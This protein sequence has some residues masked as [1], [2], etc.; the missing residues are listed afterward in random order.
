MPRREPCSK[1]LGDAAI[2]RVEQRD[3]LAENQASFPPLRVGRFFVYGSHVKRKPP[4]GALPI[5]VDATTAFGTGEHQTTRGCLLALQ[6][7]ARC[8]RPRRVLDMGTGTGILAVGAARLG[9]SRV[10]APDIDPGSVAVARINILRNGVAGTVDAFVSDG[11]RARRI[12]AAA[13]FDLVIA[14]ILARPLARMAPHLA[15][16]L[17]PGGHAVLSGLLTR[18]ETVVLAAHRAQ[19]LSLAGRIRIDG[20]TTLVLRKGG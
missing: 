1:T 4:A 14:N 5:R 10:L 19:L 16:A 18:Q 8:R 3:W 17:A 9:A 13:P 11:Y 2:E 6:R 20:W 7:L 12:A 15:R